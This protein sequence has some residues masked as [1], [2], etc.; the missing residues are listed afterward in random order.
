MAVIIILV[1][2][3]IAAL[4][5]NTLQVFLAKKAV[6]S[7]NK[8]LDGKI[9]FDRIKIRPF[10]AITLHNVRIIDNHPYRDSLNKS[11]C[12]VDTLFSAEHISVT[13]SL[14][15]LFYKRGL[16]VRTTKVKNGKLTL[17][18]EP[19]KNSKDTTIFN[20]NRIFRIKTESDTEIND[21]EIFDIS[22]LSVDNFR[23]RLK[24]VTATNQNI[25]NAIDW[26]DLDVVIHS[27]RGRRLKM[28]GSVIQGI[29]DELSFTE[30]SG[31]H[32]DNVSA[33]VKAG[34]G[35]ILIENVK[36]KDYWSNIK[37]PKILLTYKDNDS[38]TDFVSSVR[39][40][41]KIK[42]SL[43]DMQSIGFFVPE[44]KKINLA[45]EIDGQY[46]GY[47]NDF[48]L[49]NV[50]IKTCDS[51]ISGVINGSIIGL[52]NYKDIL[53]DIKLNNFNFTFSGLTKCLKDCSVNIDTTKFKSYSNQVICFNGNINGHINRLDI[54]GSANSNIGG[55]RASVN[56]RNLLD[57][58]RSLLING[59]VATDRLDIGHLLNIKEPGRCSLHTRFRASLDKNN[60]VITIDSLIINNL[61]ALGYDYKDIAAEGIYEK[62]SFNGKVISR[63]PNLKFLFQGIFAPSLKNKNAIYKFYLNVGYADLYALHLD[64]REN[65]KLDFKT[66]ADFKVLESSDIL[67]NIAIHNIMLEDAEG[68]HNV[69]DIKISSHVN[70]DL[71]RIRI[72]SNFLQA[73]YVGTGFLDE[74]INDIKAITVGK[75]MPVLFEDKIPQFSSHE[76]ELSAILHNTKDILSFFAPGMYIAD[77]TA[78]N[79]NLDKNGLFKGR[80][81]SG[82][83]AY[84]DKYLKDFN[85]IIKNNSEGITGELKASEIRLS[86]LNIKNGRITMYVNDN[87]LG[88]GLSYDNSIDTYKSGE[89]LIKGHMAKN[90]ANALCLN[91][92]ILPSSIYINSHRWN[93]G[94][95]NIY[96][97]PKKL[98]IND[99]TIN[100]D[101]QTIDISGTLSNKSADTL[102][103]GT[104][105]FDLS[106]LNTLTDN[107][108]D[109][110]G[111]MSGK[112]FISSPGSKGGIIDLDFKC[113]STY[114]SGVPMG[115]LNIDC[116]SY[117]AAK[118]IKFNCSNLIKEK[119]TLT[120]SII[121]NT[122][123]KSISGNIH[124]NGFEAGYAQ[125]FVKDIFHV[126]KGNIY[127]DL[128]C[129]GKLD[130]INIGDT[131]LYIRNGKLGIDYTKVVYNVEG[132]ASLSSKGLIFKDM[133]LTDKY[134]AKG[135]A[136]GG[137]N[138]NKFK[139]IYFNTELLFNNIE[140]INLQERE[141]PIFYGNVY[142]TG[143]FAIR[144]PI[145]SIL[146]EGN[147]STEN[148][149]KFHLPLSN[150]ST[151]SGSNLLTF[152]QPDCIKTSYTY[153]DMIESLEKKNNSESELGVK[154]HLNVNPGIVTTVEIDK[155][156]GN[157]LTGRGNGIID[158]DIRPSKDIFKI[159]GIYN[160]IGGNYHFDALG[161]VKRDLSIKDGSS[162]KFNG[163]VMD[164]ELDIK[165]SYKTKTSIGT[166]ISDTT[167][168]AR[169]NVEGIIA[170]KDKISSPKVSFDIKVPDLDPVTKALVDNALGTE[171][172]VQKQFLSLLISN[173]FLPDERSGIVNN[174]GMLNS[175]VADI[176]ASQLNNILQSL[177]I[178]VDLGL[179]YRTQNGRNV[180]DVALSTEFFDN[181][182]IVNGTIGNRKYSTTGAN[183][184]IVGDLDIEIKLDKPGALRLK[185]F[186]HSADQYTSFIDNS[187][188]NGIGLTYQREF[189]NIK[190]FLKDLFK[191]RK[192]LKKERAEAEMGR[193]KEEKVQLRIGEHQYGK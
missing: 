64:K 67:G 24:N 73:S 130:N 14:K 62:G 54:S 43:I 63:D 192:R 182:V 46:I 72:K 151:T 60:P 132:S 74:F 165:A 25:S 116:K 61:Y 158:L 21:N 143:S 11:F 185:L 98:K 89:I 123:N 117:D 57:E 163:N 69:G 79:L 90:E 6:A 15:G 103:I 81:K 9:Y 26:N 139:N 66:T 55:I 119:Q 45:A 70:N 104:D 38:W 20:L 7:L 56:V 29:S 88:L 107:K 188:R 111:L 177:D 48:S 96:L 2:G 140:A 106:L 82:R 175:T 32:A 22:R 120:S 86:P 172:K 47:V 31:Y 76:Y 189:A 169:R 159:N 5:S 27:L 174:A 166:L 95:T 191:S 112:A 138:W 144:G 178:P 124:L 113:D 91:A 37:S 92:N 180:F 186:S 171:D 148:E 164:S 108:Y 127:A 36:I 122:E 34:D 131:E 59:G 179:D 153:R 129:S 19:S 17:V 35:K 161:I 8:N 3:I 184:E 85:Y 115:T 135:Y 149:G 30:K 71:N 105:K 155:S 23:F 42:K 51:N 128:T 97:E 134:G 141:N 87:D 84:L 52:P 133:R 75:G 121:L 181:R 118:F 41:V 193:I 142:A 173:S 102:K 16:Y 33:F 99:L 10:D 44:L 170:L 53:T 77:S 49:N 109:I 4:Q 160:L 40:D 147:L 65:T 137:I 150:T 152:I 145:N 18:I 190:E 101:N 136:K 156:S 114:F 157:I 167:T 100:N 125:P 58:N 154:L 12:P 93:I 39:M 83:I 68:R 28:K 1:L 187:Q 78:I 176:M 183:N 80:I 146:L 110:S 168:T 162:I 94:G 13:F 50:S 126:I